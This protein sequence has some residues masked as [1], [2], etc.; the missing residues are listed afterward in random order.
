M[1][2]FN[3]I[4]RMLASLGI[5]LILCFG[6]NCA[7]IY[8]GTQPGKMFQD[9]SNWSYAPGTW[10]ENTETYT[11][12]N[13]SVTI[14]GYVLLDGNL[15]M[16]T[17]NNLTL[18]DNSVFII[19]GNLNISDKSDIRL[20]K[21]FTLYI[22]GNLN[23]SNGADNYW[24]LAIIQDDNSIE[25][26]LTTQSQ[27]GSKTNGRNA[28]A[29]LYPYGNNTDFYVFGNVSDNVYTTLS[30]YVDDS[31][32]SNNDIGDE[33]EYSSNE[34][35]LSITITNIETAI[36]EENNCTT[37]H[38]NRGETFIIHSGDTLEYCYI[39]FD[40]PRITYYPENRR[41][42][43][44]K[45][46]IEDG[47][48]LKL[49]RNNVI[50]SGIIENYGEIDCGTNSFTIYPRIHSN[51]GM[52]LCKFNNN[53]KFRAANFTMGSESM[54]TAE[55]Y[56]SFSCGSDFIVAN[57]ISMTLTNGVLLNGNFNAHNM[58][59]DSQNGGHRIIFG[60]D[61]GTSVVSLN[62]LTLKNNISEVNINEIT[63][64]DEINNDTYSS[65]VLNVNG[66][67]TLG[68]IE[69]KSISVSGNENSVIIV[70]YNPSHETNN[71][72]STGD[73]IY[74]GNVASTSGTLIYRYDKLDNVH[75]WYTDGS[76]NNPVIEKDFICNGCTMIA[77]SVTF[78]QCING[79]SNFLPI[80]LISFSFKH[81]E[82]IW[83]T[84]SETNND[85]FVVEYSKN[86]KDWTECTD[87]IHSASATGCTYT[88]EPIID[89]SRSLFS[90]FRLK[91]VDLDGKFS[92]SD[93]ISTSF[94][95][96]NPCSDE[97]IDTRMY[98]RELGGYYRV[99]NGQLIYCDGDN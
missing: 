25:Q 1:N 11:I 87:T 75:S 20:G 14:D 96:E 62:S 52:P 55:E 93:V 28:Y 51:T 21:N 22:K 97:Y 94:S 85:Y 82:F 5:F 57:T 61:C 59:I 73:F 69:G 39:E 72:G 83:E 54:R 9:N 88:A 80:E 67:L 44:G 64:L 17:W 99:V 66:S 37:L 90:Y 16:N 95:V 29:L 47:G 24:Y 60:K 8:G 74:N 56:F 35:D 46:I 32:K 34:T 10:N 84:A 31:N 58:I 12:T 7:T 26:D 19:D 40:E 15:T 81:D 89:V 42:E 18:N 63:G 43:A 92:Y 50:E 13:N 68:D 33:S 71:G 49:T 2:R 76:E 53:G 78:E 27:N 65:V 41:Y 98:I 36:I 30:G 6:A 4:C 45:I 48:K 23:I 3:H 70:C 38:V 79:I 77:N 91:Q 86:G